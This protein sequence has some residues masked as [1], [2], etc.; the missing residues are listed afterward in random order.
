LLAACPPCQGFSTMRTKNGT[1]WNRDRRNDLIF[2]VLR[3]VVSTRPKCVMLENVPRLAFNQR[4][5]EFRRSLETLGYLVKWDILDAVNFGVP[6]RRRRLVML[7]SRL[8]EP[9]FAP[10]AGTIRT[11]RQA[12][13][14]LTSPTRSRD[15]LHNYR[16][17]L[18]RKV[19][20]L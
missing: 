15:S 20:A 17:S 7:A 18:S 1:R 11:V 4:Y 19:K 3:F 9:L 8:S 12:I 16:S 13:K 10:Y 14:R 2:E 6:Q 5:R